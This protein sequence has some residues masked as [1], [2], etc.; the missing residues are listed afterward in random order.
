MFDPK[1]STT[2]IGH[3]GKSCPEA[4]APG[5]RALGAEAGCAKTL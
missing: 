4:A 2:A 1:R 3:D 5:R